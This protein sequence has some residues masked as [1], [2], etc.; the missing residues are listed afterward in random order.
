MTTLTV[1]QVN[2]IVG[3][4]NGADLG[5]YDRRLADETVPALLALHCE[6][7]QTEDKHGCNGY[8]W[9]CERCHRWNCYN[10]GAA[11]DHPGLC[12]DCW[13]GVTELG[14]EEE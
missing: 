4:L 2:L 7:A 8:L 11:D 9:E 3:A 14:W 6:A 12:D 10:I 1:E 13:Y 5:P